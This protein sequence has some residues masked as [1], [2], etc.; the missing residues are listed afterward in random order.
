MLIREL[1]A[2]T[3]LA[4]H[5]IRFY[6][7]EGLLDERCIVR[8][9]NNYR[10]YNEAAVERVLM[11]KHGQSVGF[12]LA[13]I[14]ELLDAWDAGRLTLAEQHARIT[15]KLAEVEEKLARLHD[16][17]GYLAAKQARLEAAMRTGG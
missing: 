9:G 12:T 3:G 8:A 13:E 5:T 2:R 1:A 17:R 7:K 14:R 6:E 16:L 4:P 10:H 15:C 11:V